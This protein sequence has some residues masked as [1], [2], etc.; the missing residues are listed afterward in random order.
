MV[1]SERKVLVRFKFVKDQYIGKER[2][3]CSE[4]VGLWAQSS[5]TYHFSIGID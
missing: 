1:M 5:G 4:Y 3:N 2:G